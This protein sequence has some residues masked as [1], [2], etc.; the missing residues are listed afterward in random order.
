MSSYRRVGN[1][2]H[3][4]L[5]ELAFVSV[6]GEGRKGSASSTSNQNNVY[7]RD[8]LKG[9]TD[10]F[11]HSLSR[12]DE[13][14][15]KFET[16]SFDLDKSPLDIDQKEQ[17][18]MRKERDIKREERRVERLECNKLELEKFNTIIGA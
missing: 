18:E 9:D 2:K 5:S 13:L 11:A 14:S 8:L 6:E 3:L 15:S 4:Y 1:Y 16:E 7:E 12:S 10:P 17:E